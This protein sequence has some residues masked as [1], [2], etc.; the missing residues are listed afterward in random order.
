MSGRKY[1]F[2]ESTL[3]GKEFLFGFF[4]V[5]IGQAIWHV[6]DFP[7]SFNI[8]CLG[9]LILVLVYS[10]PFLRFVANPSGVYI[11]NSV[12]HFPFWRIPASDIRGVAVLPRPAQEYT[13]YFGMLLFDIPAIGWISYAGS[14]KGQG[15]VIVTDKR[16][17]LLS[18]KN[19]EEAAAE[20]RGIYK[21]PEVTV[22]VPLWKDR[23]K[24]YWQWK[25]R[26][27][28]KRVIKE[29]RRQMPQ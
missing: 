18:C 24:P 22:S 11:F 25:D 14:L 6:I 20:I 1:G 23:R 3:Q 10:L 15:L 26:D 8:A 28:P 27:I 21:V 2:I 16:N 29:F 19:A 12:L 7:I 17:Y 5:L 13:R 9:I 4:S